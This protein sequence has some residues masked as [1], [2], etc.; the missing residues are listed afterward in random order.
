MKYTEYQTSQEEYISARFYH[1]HF[2]LLFVLF[3]FP[4][5]LFGAVHQ[6]MAADT[7][8]P[9]KLEGRWQRTDGSYIL[10]LSA[11]QFDGQLTT[12]YFN[13][14]PINV[15]RSMWKYKEGY[16]GVYVELRAPNYPGSTYRLLY[17]SETDTLLGLY[18]QATMQQEFEVEF[19]RIS[20]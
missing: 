15:S 13:P 10:E 11:P 9:G 4:C 5:M 7:S 20:E 8:D 14:R 17:D 1:Q 18:F 2:L 12:L 19:R 6:V 3:L 16:L